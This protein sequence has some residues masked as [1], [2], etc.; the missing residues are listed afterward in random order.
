M[1]P[2]PEVDGLSALEELVQSAVDSRAGG[3]GHAR[4]Q[5]P[6]RSLEDVRREWQVALDTQMRYAR[7]GRSEA[8]QSIMMLVSQ[9][10]E[11]S[12]S[13]DWWDRAGPA[14]TAE[15]IRY[16]VFDSAVPSRNAHLL[17]RRAMDHVPARGA[18]L[19][20]WERWHRD[21]SEASA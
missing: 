18:W 2:Q 13:V 4:P 9:L 16:T 1:D 20:E 3:T 19:S 12:A 15:A 5:G 11:L 21:W 8:N 7:Q 17:W 6:R 14:A 10:R